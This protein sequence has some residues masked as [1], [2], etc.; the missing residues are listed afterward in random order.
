MKKFNL[1]T[2]SWIIVVVLMLLSAA[3][4]R[5]N[6]SPA[7]YVGLIVAYVG[8]LLI[9]TFSNKYVGILGGA[10]TIALGIL[11]R[12][13]LPVVSTL[14][15]EK[16]EAFLVKET[17]YNNFISKYLILL[18]LAGALVGFIGGLI[19][20]ILAKDKSEKFT[21][22][23]LT[24]M[25]V[26]VALGVIINTLRVGG[27]SFGGFPIILSGYLLGPVS[28]FIVG[29][30]TDLAAFIVRPS[31]FGFNPIF[32][33]TSALTGLLP[34]LVTSILGETYPKF[35]FIKVLIGVFVGQ[36]LTSVILV[37]IFSTLLYGQASFLVLAGKAL[38]KQAFSIPL[39]AFLAVTLIDRM[40]KVIKFDRIV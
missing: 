12:K 17:A 14:K 2:K 35:T 11:A 23:K 25:A 40:A 26:L 8:I 13:I 21:P 15:G 19:G 27:I 34:V 1:N 18:I 28:G 3:S 36:I 9:G 39:Y 10:L 7:I 6:G 38:A 29:A 22:N 31:A 37:P 30:V 20:E 32:T 24:Y 33:I 4:I 16:L 5:T